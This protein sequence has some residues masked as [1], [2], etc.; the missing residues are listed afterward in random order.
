MSRYRASIIHLLISAFIVGNVVAVVFW[1][2]YPSPA[3]EVVGAFPILRLLVGVD[4]VLG[5]LLTLV[6]YKHGKPGLKFD[7]AFIACVQII[8]LV[9]GSYVLFTERPRY[10]VFTVDR[11]EFVAANQVDETEIRFD[12]LRAKEIATLIRA[13]ASAP[14]DPEEYQ[15]YFDSVMF[16][17]KP[18]LERRPEYWQPWSAGVDTIRQKIKTFEGMNPVSDDESAALRRAIENYAG[19]NV[20]VLPVGGIE[21]DIGVVVDVETLEIL[22]V[23]RV[24]PWP[25]EELPESDDSSSE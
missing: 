7:L 13:F 23:L 11:V 3:F 12:E 18:D 21:D 20:G 14:Q 24:N 2:W 5:P 25:S 9:Y 17:G 10:V 1:A 4:L 15:R 8:A 16:E 19:A 22:S 6:V